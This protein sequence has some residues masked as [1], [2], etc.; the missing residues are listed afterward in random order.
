[1]KAIVAAHAKESHCPEK[2]MQERTML[3]C[4]AGGLEQTM[5]CISQ[6]NPWMGSIHTD[7]FS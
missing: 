2:Q 4:M 3:G 6:K 5:G 7:T 1:M